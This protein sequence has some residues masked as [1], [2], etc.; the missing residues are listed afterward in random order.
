MKEKRDQNSEVH[1]S[2]LIADREGDRRQRPQEVL[3][4]PKKGEV[5]PFAKPDIALAWPVGLGVN[6]RYAYIGD[7]LNRRLMRVTFTYAADE[8]CAIK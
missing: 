2:G 8:T 1:S 6:D 3:S 4:P 7:S 5:S